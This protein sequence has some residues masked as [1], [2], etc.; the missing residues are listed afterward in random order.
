MLGSLL[1]NLINPHFGLDLSSLASFLAVTAAIVV[2]VAVPGAINLE[3]RR[4]RH[5]AEQAR[6]FLK[7]LPAGLAI[8]AGCVLVSRLA[9]FAPGYLYGL[10]C[11][12]AFSRELAKHEKGHVITLSTVATLVLATAVWLAWAPVQASVGHG[13]AGFGLVLLDDFLASLFVSGLVGSVI[14][15]LPLRFLP[16]GDVAAWHRG[17]W[18]A[19]FGV[20]LFGMLQAMLRPVSHSHVGHAPIVTVIILLVLFGGG[21]LAFRQH[22]ARRRK[23][24]EEPEAQ[25]AQAQG[26]AAEA[27]RAQAP[28]V[29]QGQAEPSPEGAE[30][31]RPRLPPG[32]RV[33]PQA[34]TRPAGFRL[35][36]AGRA[37]GRPAATS[38]SGRTRRPGRGRAG[39]GR[40]WRRAGCPPPARWPGP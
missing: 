19:I 6:P 22:F 31:R 3:Y 15:M 27:S 10:I 40:Q 17:A 25:A 7:A 38:S 28:M 30:G 13:H 2:G 34:F 9:S 39:P 18:A 21:S 32:P 20:A 11:G 8:A 33:G 23:K 5:G 29:G 37:A 35:V 26:P 16:G 14:G 12:V 24:P 36:V 1:G 4:H